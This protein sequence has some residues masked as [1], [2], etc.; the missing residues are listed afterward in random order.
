M[1]VKKGPVT[2]PVLSTKPV[3]NITLYSAT[4]GGIIKSDGGESI[5]AYGVCWNTTG[6][7][8]VTDSN[9][10]ETLGANMFVSDIGDL[11]PNTIYYLRA[12][13]YNSSGTGYGE[14]LT[15]KTDVDTT[16]LGTR[17]VDIDGNVYNTVAIEGQVWMKENLRTTKYNNGKAI[18][19]IIDATNWYNCTNGAYCDWGN[20]ESISTHME[21]CTT[22][23]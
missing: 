9:T 8:K 4:S 16:D 22:G 11:N 12:Y 21:D 3:I 19:E 2:T 5:Y 17:V 14:E 10:S 23:L 15:F 7:P 6:N 1:G 13:A 20:I 18:P